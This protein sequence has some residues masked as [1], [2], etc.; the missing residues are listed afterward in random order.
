[1]LAAGAVAAFVV[2]LV[3]I[4][5]IESAVGK[6]LAA[7]IGNEQGGGT[8]IGR[9]VGDTPAQVTDEPDTNPTPTPSRTAERSTTDSPTRA[10]SPAGGRPR[11]PGADRPA[12]HGAVGDPATGEHPGPDPRPTR[13]P[14]GHP[15]RVPGAPSS[16]GRDPWT[17][18]AGQLHHGDE[19]VVDLLD[20]LG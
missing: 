13:P 7:L 10:T 3:A 20:H 5:G 1:M 12:H 11:R 4:T 19:E 8:T 6:P 9:T 14:P 17:G 18:S 16:A 15:A 2:A